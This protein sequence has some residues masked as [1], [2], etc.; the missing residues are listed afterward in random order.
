MALAVTEDLQ[1]MAALQVMGHHC[2][3]W[4]ELED[5]GLDWSKGR[6]AA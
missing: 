1:A 6:S 5:I 2:R 3:Y 4:F